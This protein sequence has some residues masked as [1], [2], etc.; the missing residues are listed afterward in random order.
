MHDIQDIQNIQNIRHNQTTTA[1]LCI[2]IVYVLCQIGDFYYY[3]ILPDSPYFAF[4]ISMSF[5]F[6]INGIVGVQLSLYF[7]VYYATRHYQLTTYQPALS[8]TISITI[9]FGIYWT[10]IG[11]VGFIP[12]KNDYYHIYL[13]SKLITQ[14]LIYVICSMVYMST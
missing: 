3:I 8:F 11:W 14:S 2:S 12:V 1:V 13:G 7:I 10:V 4:D 9:L 5:W 6:L